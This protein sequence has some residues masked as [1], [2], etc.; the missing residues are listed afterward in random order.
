MTYLEYL[1]TPYWQ[2]KRERAL[3]YYF[4]Q[5][6]L[7]GTK[8]HLNVHHKRYK[9]D[10]GNSIWFHEGMEDLSVLCTEHHSGYHKELEFELLSWD[11]I[12]ITEP[13]IAIVNIEEI[14]KLVAD[15]NLMLEH[16]KRQ[17]SI[18]NHLRKLNGKEP[19]IR[20]YSWIG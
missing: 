2:N 8:Y 11:N 1:Q 3:Q 7:C 4:N 12:E 17:D 19:I 6:S 10:E 5:C 20:D 13:K 14:R 15:K 9:D 18:I 16:L